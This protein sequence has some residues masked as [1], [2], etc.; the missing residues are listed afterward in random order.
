M[1]IGL[2]SSKPQSGKSTVKDVFVEYGFVAE[3]F[4]TPVKES[5]LVVLQS[6]Q[7]VEPERYLWG[8]WKGKIIPEL[9]VTGGYLMSTY[10]TDYFRDSVYLHT[11]RNALLYRLQHDVDYVVDDMRFPN[12]YYLFDYTIRVERPSSPDHDRS[13]KSEGLLDDFYFDFVIPNDG[14]ILVL[15][16]YAVGVLQNIISQEKFYDL[17]CRH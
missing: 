14:D 9:G 16:N 2:Y 5:L 10:A 1:L 3:S 17:H 15:K 6:L 11:W 4:A 13:K 7:V 8:D 12:E